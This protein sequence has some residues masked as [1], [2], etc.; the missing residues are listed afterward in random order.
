[1]MNELIEKLKDNE[2]LFGRL[3]DKSKHVFRMV[4]KDNCVYY[5]GTEWDECYGGK[6]FGVTS[7]YRIKRKYQ[8][9]K[10]SKYI[11]Y[12]IV[13]IETTGDD[14]KK[15]YVNELY[16]FLV[17]VIGMEGFIGIEY[18]DGVV[19]DIFPSFNCVPFKAYLIDKA[20]PNSLTPVKVWFRK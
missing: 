16:E 7:L 19:R 6:N 18:E 9:E 11:A 4:G 14:K 17:N 2:L 15:Y 10:E 3:D 12:D 8:P 1:M 20:I 13:L 5:N